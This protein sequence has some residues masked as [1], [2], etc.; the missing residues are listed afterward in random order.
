MSS[1]DSQ[2]EFVEEENEGLTKRTKGRQRPAELLITLKR[3]RKP[4]HIV[5]EDDDDDNYNEVVSSQ[6][7]LEEDQYDTPRHA[8]NVPDTLS[9]VAMDVPYNGRLQPPSLYAF[10][11]LPT[12]KTACF[13]VNHRLDDISIAQQKVPNTKR[14]RRS[15]MS[16]FCPLA[17]NKRVWDRVGRCKSQSPFT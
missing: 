8:D 7:K 17:S 6:V 12:H 15:S 11:Q 13:E 3:A 4:T 2:D 1:E 16:S 14:K 5:S 10:D 9:V